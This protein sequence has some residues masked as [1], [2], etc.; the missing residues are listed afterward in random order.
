MRNIEVEDYYLQSIHDDLTTAFIQYQYNLDHPFPSV[1]KESTA[2]NVQICSP[3]GQYQTN[4][5]FRNKVDSFVAGVLQIV[6]K[7]V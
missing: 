7:H 4:P 3:L 1:P 2:T 6:Q 5:Q